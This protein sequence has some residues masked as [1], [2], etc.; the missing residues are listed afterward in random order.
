MII[1]NLLKKAFPFL[2]PPFSK[3]G[4]GGT[5]I[6]ALLLSASVHAETLLTGTVQLADQREVQFSLSGNS[7]EDIINGEIRLGDL[8]FRIDKQSRMGLIGAQRA[9]PELGETALEY[10]VFSSS[11]SSQ[12][13]T[14]QPWVSARDYYLCNQPYNAFLALYQVVDSHALAELGPVPYPILAEGRGAPKQALVYCFSA[15]P[16]GQ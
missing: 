7:R 9:L 4:L 10:A 12:T 14:G 1:K 15:Q 13:A 3:G 8:A 16:P 6:L 5:G 2:I 11:F